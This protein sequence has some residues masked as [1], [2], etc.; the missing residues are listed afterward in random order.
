MNNRFY[1]FLIL[2]FCF[3]IALIEIHQGCTRNLVGL[4][5]TRQIF[6]TTQLIGGG[7]FISA[8]ELASYFQDAY[9]YDALSGTLTFHRGDGIRVG[10]KVGDQRILVGKTLIN[11]GMVPIRQNGRIYI[12]F[13]IVDTFLFPTVRFQEGGEV[14]QA[15]A[16]TPMESPTEIP[17]PPRYIFTYPT[18]PESDEIPTPIP[19]RSSIPVYSVPT[20]YPEP[21]SP[22]PDPRKPLAAVVVLDPGND[23]SRPGAVAPSG[24]R[25]CDLTLSICN[26]IANELSKTH[27]VVLTR[28][29]KETEPISAI[30]R[31]ELANR[32]KGSLFVSIHCGALLTSELSRSVIYFMN[33]RLDFHVGAED[34]A[35]SPA[36][37]LITW[38]DAYQ[39]HMGE[40]YQ[41]AQILNQQL[42]VFYSNTSLVKLDSNPRPGRMAILRGLTMPGVVVE[43]GNLANNETARYL[44]SDVIQLDVAHYLATAITDYLYKRAGMKG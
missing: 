9:L 41:L 28:K 8:F 36:S 29:G 15:P 24:L 3:W 22:V 4:S 31:I 25:E 32:A 30:Q 20:P 23:A 16:P 44:G 17:T 19:T 21:V 35:L 14:V 26:K 13:Y 7:E 6:F 42:S 38:N 37:Q 18:R 5:E 39:R 12:P 43:L 10:M 40:S 11:T 1:C 27:E 34:L 33:E 2:G